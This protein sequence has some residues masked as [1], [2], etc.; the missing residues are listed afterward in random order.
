MIDAI[1]QD[2]R[3]ARRRT[4]RQ[5]WAVLGVLFLLAIAITGYQEYYAR[6]LAG[7]KPIDWQTM[8]WETAERELD[9]GRKMLIVILDET[10][11]TA[12]QGFLKQFETAEIREQVYRSRLLPL[13]LSAA[14]D[15]EFFTLIENRFPVRAIPC[16]VLPISKQKTIIFD[17][18]MTSQAIAGKIVEARR[19]RR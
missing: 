8:D 13:K 14:P 12:S 5:L 4:R 3:A 2:V 15:S 1:E 19:S 10:D 6:Y 7:E 17:Q 18:G 9:R 11:D 16:G